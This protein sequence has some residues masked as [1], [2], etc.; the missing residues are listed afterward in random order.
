MLKK[1]FY[2]LILGFVYSSSL[3]QSSTDLIIKKKDSL[4]IMYQ[5]VDIL[6]PSK[7]A[8][9]SA[10]LPGLGQAYNKKYWKIPIVWGALG[11]STYFYI[12]NNNRYNE[13]RTAFKLRLGNRADA[14]NGDGEKPNLSV[15]ALERAQK[16]YRKNRDLSLFVIIGFYILNIVEAN[17]DAHLPDHALNTNLSFNPAI[18]TDPVT[19]QSVFGANLSF[20]F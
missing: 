7:A 18:F 13:Y 10:V 17:V 11:T 19:N 20:E 4:K 9:Y 15:N 14:F 1:A 16:F 8:F 2:I 3:A 12:R 5:E 6:A